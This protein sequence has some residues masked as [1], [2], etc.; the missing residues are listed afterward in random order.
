[1]TATYIQIIYLNKGVK[2]IA[3]VNLTSLSHK[4]IFGYQNCTYVFHS[5]TLDHS[6]LNDFHFAFIFKTKGIL[7]ISKK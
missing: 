5:L 3:L 1:M 6:R 4:D 2:V 7:T